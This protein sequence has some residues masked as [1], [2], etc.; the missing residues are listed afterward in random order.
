MK[1]EEAYSILCVTPLDND[2]DIKKSYRNLL[3]TYHPDICRDSD[4]A[5]SKTKLINEAYELIGKCRH[6]NNGVEYE[7]WIIVDYEIITTDRYSRQK[8]T[9]IHQ[10]FLTRTFMGERGFRN[11]WD[12]AIE[13]YRAFVLSFSDDA[14]LFLQDIVRPSSYIFYKYYVDRICELAAEEYVEK[15]IALKYNKQFTNSKS[16]E[17]NSVTNLVDS[18][19]VD[20]K[21][22]IL[23]EKAK[24]NF[25]LD[26][27]DK[28]YS[29]SIKSYSFLDYFVEGV[30]PDAHSPIY[31]FHYNVSLSGNS[32][33]DNKIVH[34]HNGAYNY[35]GITNDIAF[36]IAT[37][38]QLTLNYY[39]IIKLCKYKSRVYIWKYKTNICVVELK[40]RKYPN[41]EE[42]FYM[43]RVSIY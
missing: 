29:M 39:D 34:I 26:T 9:A 31:S 35:D 30:V 24:M 37:T 12:P 20:N 15:S 21:E 3:K 23:C 28:A 4:I 16:I 7:R 22:L 19:F 27:I 11:I 43:A 41:N 18:C 5:E 33:P 14:E 42:Y 17:D 6:G 1:I 2:A 25:V 40:K 13:D 32:L 8:Q 36:M 38:F 10:G